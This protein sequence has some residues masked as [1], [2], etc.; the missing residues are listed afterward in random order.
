M[1]RQ[2]SGGIEPGTP[3]WNG[4]LGDAI[5]PTPTTLLIIIFF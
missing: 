2:V 5:T 3:A 1:R 4:R